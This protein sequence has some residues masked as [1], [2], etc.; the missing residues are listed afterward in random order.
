MSALGNQHINNV[1]KFSSISYLLVDE[2]SKSHKRGLTDFGGL[3][4]KTFFGT[5]DSEDAV[6]FTDAIDKIQ[7]DEKQL[8]H[9]MKDNIHVIKST[10]STLNQSMS[11]ANENEKRLLKNMEI[12][13]EVIIKVSNSNDKLEIKSQLNSLMN[14]LESIILTLSFD[15]DDVNNAILFAK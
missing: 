4:L 2:Q 9:L 11:K 15:I 5:L 7:S 8:A 14:S 3:I 1:N 12:I 10:L 13:E 6:K